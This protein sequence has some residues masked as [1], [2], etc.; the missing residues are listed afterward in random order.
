MAISSISGGPPGGASFQAFRAKFEDV[1][2]NGLSKDQ[3]TKLDEKLKAK[4]LD[5]K[6][7]D[8][9]I[10]N[11]DSLDADKSG[12]VSLSEIKGGAKQ[13]GIDVP[14]GPPPQINGI[15]GQTPPP[16]LFGPP[17]GGP[18]GDGDGDNDKSGSTQGVQGAKHHGHHKHGGGGGGLGQL[19]AIFGLSNP[20]TSTP[21]SRSSSSS[22]SQSAQQ[23]NSGFNPIDLLG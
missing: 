18:Q 14:Q 21:T 6:N 7:L 23:G 1:E 16:G 9:I 12:K 8:K 20:P 5:T 3:L 4:G 17:P 22:S 15:L 13:L 10:K 2:K 19:A 11:F